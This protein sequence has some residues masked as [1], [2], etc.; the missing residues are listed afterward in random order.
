MRDDVI[1]DD[2][3]LRGTSEYAAEQEVGTPGLAHGSRI[4]LM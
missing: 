3:V 1:R 4:R 2:D